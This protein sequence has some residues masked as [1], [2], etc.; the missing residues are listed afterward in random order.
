[1]LNT[2][3]K[4]LQKKEAIERLKKLNYFEDHLEYFIKENIVYRTESDGI[5]F[6]LSEEEQ[7]YVSDFENEYGALVFHVIKNIT[8]FGTLYN[9]LYVSEHE[10]EWKKDLEFEQTGEIYAFAYVLNI[11]IP[12]FSEFG[13]IRIENRIGGIIR[14]A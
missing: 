3:L 7:K 8:E 11:S 13:F 10:E 9:F 6:F 5:E 4:D 1:M 12:E 2:N 14:T